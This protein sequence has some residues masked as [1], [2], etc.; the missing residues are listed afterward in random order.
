MEEKDHGRK[1]HVIVRGDH[2][3]MGEKFWEQGGGRRKEEGR[4]R[5]G[6]RKEGGE[7]SL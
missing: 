4:G 6:R 1:G 5:R 2:E 3:R 7:G